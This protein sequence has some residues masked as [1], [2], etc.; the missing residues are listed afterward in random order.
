MAV[1][2]K[3]FFVLFAV[4]RI[5]DVPGNDSLM[6]THDMPSIMAGQADGQGEF[7]EQGKLA[8]RARASWRSGPGQAGEFDGHGQTAYLL[9]C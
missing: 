3:R 4:C 1:Q 9:Y 7:D 6:R 2:C 5:D 8:V